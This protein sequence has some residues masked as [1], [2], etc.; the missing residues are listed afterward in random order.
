MPVDALVARAAFVIGC[1]SVRRLPL[2][3]ALIAA[4]AQVK[5]AVLVHR[6][7]HM[8]AIPAGLVNQLDLA[9]PVDEADSL[10]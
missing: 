2:V 4:V 10:D 6:D 1:R 9:N 5:Q 3:D 8:R 7:E